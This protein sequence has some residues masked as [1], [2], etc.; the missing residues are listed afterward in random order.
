[1]G[2]FFGNE[3]GVLFFSPAAYHLLKDRTEEIYYGGKPENRAHAA[4]RKAGASAAAHG[5][6]YSAGGAAGSAGRGGKAGE[7]AHGSHSLSGSG[8][9][10]RPVCG[11]AAHGNAA[12]ADR[13]RP[14]G[15]ESGYPAALCAQKADAFSHSPLPVPRRTDKTGYPYARYGRKGDSHTKG[16]IGW[17]GQRHK[18]RRWARNGCG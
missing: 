3:K 6:G 7:N 1:M 2:Q 8:I 9:P 18:W 15:A 11:G 17:T 13:R 12:D 4:G 14:S 10:A 16:G 5:A